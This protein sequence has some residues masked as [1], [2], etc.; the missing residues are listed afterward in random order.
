MIEKG[1]CHCGCGNP[2]KIATRT[3]T[4]YGWVK[5][6]PQFYLR[7]HAAWKESGPKWIIN[8]NGCWIWQR[9]L[10]P[11]GYGMGTFAR[12]GHPG[13]H[14][15]HRVLYQEKHGPIPDSIL[16]DH[17]CHTNDTDCQGGPTCPHRQCVNPDHVEPV[18][19]LENVHRGVL[20]KATELDIKAVYELRRRG[21]SWRQIAPR[22]GMTHPPLI[23]RLR[24]HC[25]AN[26][27]EWP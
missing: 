15:A 1:L 19:P 13:H 17:T 25:E 24:K 11:E 16:L 7:G 2:T 18:T 22:F 26:G 10:N 3:S 21:I 27:L 5:G 20:L 8:E 14:L 6:E 23:T 4:R 12:L 9:A